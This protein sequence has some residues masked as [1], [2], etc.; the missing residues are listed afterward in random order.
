MYDILLFGEMAVDGGLSHARRLRHVAHGDLGDGARAK[1]PRGGL[2]DKVALDVLDRHG[3][4]LSRND[5][6]SIILK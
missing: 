4:L 1:Q 2:H 3:P 6:Q 5:R